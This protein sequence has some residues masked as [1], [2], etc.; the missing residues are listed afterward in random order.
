[1]SVMS[2]ALLAE[3]KTWNSSS[4][5]KEALQC[6]IQPAVLPLT[7]SNDAFHSVKV[8]RS[9]SLQGRMSPG[10]AFWLDSAAVWLPTVRRHMA[11]ENGHVLD[12]DIHL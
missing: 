4:N 8:V 11:C 10:G 7:P 6:T 5:R 1:M 12:A 9:Y 2:A 3:D